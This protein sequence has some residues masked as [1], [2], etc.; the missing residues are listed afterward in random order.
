M[1]VLWTSAGCAAPAPCASSADASSRASTAPRCWSPAGVPRPCSSTPV[2]PPVA[3]SAPS[4]PAAAAASAW[5]SGGSCDSRYRSHA[6]RS[7]CAACAET[8]HSHQ[9]ALLAR[10]IAAIHHKSVVSKSFCALSKTRPRR[11][12]RPTALSCRSPETV[13]RAW[14]HLHCLLAA[15]PPPT[16]E[17]ATC[18]SASAHL[19]RAW[20]TCHAQQRTNGAKAHPPLS[21]IPVNSTQAAPP[22]AHP[23]PYSAK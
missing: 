21:L 1:T 18:F 15:K 9:Q 12:C 3:G 16:E 7:A 17:Q 11:L 2:V 20:L 14:H 23:H 6:A 13:T 4:S 8:Q 19:Q 10:L 22:M 5:C